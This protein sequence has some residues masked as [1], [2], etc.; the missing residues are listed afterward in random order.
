MFDT[1]NLLVL[2]L[3]PVFA[4]TTGAM[5]FFVYELLHKKGSPSLFYRK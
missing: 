2:T 1:L 5:M 4:Y 3:A